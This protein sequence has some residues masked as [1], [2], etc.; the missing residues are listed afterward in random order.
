MVCGRGMYWVRLGKEAS[1]SGVGLFVVE[2]VGVLYL[3][4][5]AGWLG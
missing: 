4:L 3:A 5:L 2:L 1:E